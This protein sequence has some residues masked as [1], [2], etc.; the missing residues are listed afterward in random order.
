M[1]EYIVALILTV[2][3]ILFMR[4]YNLRT[5]V[6]F[7][8][9]CPDGAMSAAIAKKWLTGAK[10]LPWNHNIG[11]YDVTMRLTM[12][13]ILSGKHRTVYFLDCCP[14]PEQCKLL[15]KEKVK[16]IVLDHHK[17]S[18]DAIKNIKHNNLKIM[19]DSYRSGCGLC[20][21]Y[22]HSNTFMKSPISPRVVDY[23]QNADLFQFVGHTDAFTTG[24][25]VLH[26]K[27]DNMSPDESIVHMTK[28]LKFDKEEI[29]RCISAGKLVIANSQNI[30]KKE[31][32]IAESVE[33]Y[34]DKWIL[35]EDVG[36]IDSLAK[37]VSLEIYDRVK[38]DIFDP[39]IKFFGFYKYPKDKT[40]SLSLR[41]PVQKGVSDECKKR[42]G[43][44]HD[45]AGGFRLDCT[46][47]MPTNPLMFREW[48]RKELN[49]EA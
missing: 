2:G 26:D 43:G 7:H 4:W 41:S 23:I 31:V 33:I 34:G 38:L 35:F 39:D 3:L 14:T 6:V 9:P 29:K 28:V 44:G 8:Y 37:F 45:F 19:Y 15:L 11:D 49:N 22:F 1:L 18:V 27:I 30:A 25:P 17:S 20:W 21:S 5:V 47:D 16:V 40:I 10:Y 48:L 24:L 13:Y 32:N 42:G 46:D 12:N 36:V